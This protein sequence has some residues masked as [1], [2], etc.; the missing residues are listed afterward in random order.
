MKIEAPVNCPS[1]G[2]KLEYKNDILYCKNS[3]CTSQQEKALQHW[4]KT[5]KIKGLGPKTIQALGITSII[6]LYLLDKGDLEDATG[7]KVLAEK[8]KKEIDN[9]KKLP[10]NYMLPAFS[11]PL[12]G[13]TASEKICAVIDSIHDISMETMKEAGLGPKAASN[14]VT[15]YN[16]TFLKE[17]DGVLQFSLKVDKKVRPKT[18]KGVVCITGRL[19]TFKTKAEA[20][21]FLESAGYTV[22]DSITKD[23]TILINE[24]GKS[25]A[26]TEQ[27]LK[28]GVSVIT[29]IKQLTGDLKK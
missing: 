19:E 26:K 12:I 9:S 28:N 5:L 10:L 15:W 8:L 18:T 13:R 11:I 16:N 29:N 20:K 4:A 27:A 6:D 22:K 25:S 3:Q 23:V 1:C 14:V 21:V 7:S 2:Y 17:F 24:S